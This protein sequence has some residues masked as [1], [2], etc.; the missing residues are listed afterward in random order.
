MR[1]YI[2]FESRSTY[3]IDDVCILSQVSLVLRTFSQACYASCL[4]QAIRGSRCCF[5]VRAVRAAGCGLAASA[6]PPGCSVR[7][8]RFL[9]VFSQKPG[10]VFLPARLPKSPERAPFPSRK[11]TH[12][13]AHSYWYILLLSWY[14]DVKYL[15]RMIAKRKKKSIAVY[16]QSGR[17]LGRTERPTL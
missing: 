15:Y 10:N 4:Q 9:E 8:R 3:T 12:A 7:A 6:G 11:V 14:I 1:V 13:C 5:S 2:N 17:S 16:S